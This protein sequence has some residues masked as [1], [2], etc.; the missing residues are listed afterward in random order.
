MYEAFKVNNITVSFSVTIP[1]S[2][3]HYWMFGFPIIGYYG[4]DVLLDGNLK[5][6]GFESGSR[7]IFAHNHSFVL[8]RLERGEHSVKILITAR[9]FYQNPNSDGSNYL[10][11][12]RNMSVTRNFRVDLYSQPSPSPTPTIPEYPFLATV[13]F[14]IAIIVLY[15]ALVRIKQSNGISKQDCRQ[16]KEEDEELFF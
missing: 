6:E 8:D 5:Y 10:E 12:V 9:T 4:F 1:D 3:N 15:L 14:A 11:H 7:D 2:W 16:G 13:I